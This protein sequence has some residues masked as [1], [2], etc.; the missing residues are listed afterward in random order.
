[1]IIISDTYF[2]NFFPIICIYL[3]HLLLSGVGAH[4]SDGSVD[5]VPDAG[6]V[7][8]HADCPGDAAAGVEHEVLAVVSPQQLH[9]LRH[10]DGA[11]LTTVMDVIV[12]VS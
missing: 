12:I 5:L 2:R 11:D 6:H 4:V 8:E 9:V 1:M 10:A 7:S 3:Y